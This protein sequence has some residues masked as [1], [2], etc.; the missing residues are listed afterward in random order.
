MP[1]DPPCRIAF[2]DG[3]QTSRCII[4]LR[5]GGAELM[6]TCRFSEGAAP[7]T[8]T[9]DIDT[10]ADAVERLA[11]EIVACSTDHSIAPAWRERKAVLAATTLRALARENAELR[12][13]VAGWIEAFDRSTKLREQDAAERR[14]LVAEMTRRSLL[15][16]LQEVDRE[17][18]AQAAAYAETHGVAEGDRPADPERETVRCRKCGAYGSADDLAEQRATT[19]KE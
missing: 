1:S 15:P 2:N 11:A 6:K 18:L 13:R 9:P 5:I 7:M 17:W 14:H 4:C 8:D 19:G 3:L 10:S 16:V 12:A